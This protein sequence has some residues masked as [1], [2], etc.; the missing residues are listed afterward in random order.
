LKKVKLSIN[1]IG[2]KL[3]SRSKLEIYTKL[4]FMTVYVFINDIKIHFFLVFLCSA[5]LCYIFLV[6]FH[7][8]FLWWFWESLIGIESD[9][10][11]FKCRNFLPE[12]REDGGG[13]VSYVMPLSLFMMTLKAL[14]ACPVCLGDRQC[15]SWLSHCATSW[16]VAGTN[17]DG[18]FHLH[19]PSGRTMA[20]LTTQPLI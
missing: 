7:A 1:K 19:N 16:R 6:K 5:H 2:L 20:L 17:F 14:L 8:N 15:R 11:K 13:C 12:G 3:K 10:I 9:G 4:E 18:I